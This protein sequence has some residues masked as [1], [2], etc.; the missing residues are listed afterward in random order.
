[1]WSNPSD[2]E[3]VSRCLAGDRESFGI[4][5]RRYQPRFLRLAAAALADRSAAEDVVQETF[6]RAFTRL[7]RYR[8]RGSFSAWLYTIFSHGLKD[9]L[10]QRKRY[11]GFLERLTQHY[12]HEET[13]SEESAP[14]DT[15]WIC[16]ALAGLSP[17]Q[18][19]CIFLRDL[20]GLSSADVAAQLGI[21]EA[22]VRVHLL[23]GR[24][25]LREIY[26][27]KIRNAPGGL[28]ADQR[29]P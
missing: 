4:I 18:R 26:E 23:R 17:M 6:I 19:L 25:K 1:M 2:E 29:D 8:P 27:R 5:V 21:E 22:T 20:E 14:R 15:S 11:G 3:V 16:P 13:I 12:R 7:E 10:R 24:R 28:P 9:H